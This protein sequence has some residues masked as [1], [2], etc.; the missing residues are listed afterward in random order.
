MRLKPQSQ[1]NREREN[2]LLCWWEVHQ[3]SRIG[4]EVG[5]EPEAVSHWPVLGNRKCKDPVVGIQQ[6]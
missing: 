2:A 5:F 4:E 6:P 3:S 1:V